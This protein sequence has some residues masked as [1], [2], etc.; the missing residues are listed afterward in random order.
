M[1]HVRAFPIQSGFLP[2][3][4]SSLWEFL[5]RKLMTLAPRQLKPAPGSEKHTLVCHFRKNE[6]TILR[7][8]Y[9][10]FAMFISAI[11]LSEYRVAPLNEIARLLHEQLW[12]IKCA[13][14]SKEAIFKEI[15]NNAWL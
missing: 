8:T 14:I 5:G 4:I 9:G 12:P 11:H 10:I 2:S 6:H 13:N 1:N 7:S 15:G 3:A